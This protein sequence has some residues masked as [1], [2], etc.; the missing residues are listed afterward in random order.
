MEMLGE[1]SRAAILLSTNN[2]S[3]VPFLRHGLDHGIEDNNHGVK[4]SG[5]LIG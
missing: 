5:G 1:S 4:V 2:K 3:A